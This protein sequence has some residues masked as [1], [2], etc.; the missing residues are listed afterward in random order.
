MVLCVCVHL[1]V[2]V[3]GE[4]GNLLRIYWFVSEEKQ[5][6]DKDAVTLWILFTPLGC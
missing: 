4:K 6:R 3:F 1:C 2:C 5:E